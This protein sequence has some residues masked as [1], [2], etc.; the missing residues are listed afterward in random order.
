MLSQPNVSGEWPTELQ[1]SVLEHTRQ[2][3]SAAFAACGISISVRSR[4]VLRRP[5]PART[6]H[7]D[8]DVNEEEQR[9]VESLALDTLATLSAT[10]IYDERALGGRLGCTGGYEE[11][12]SSASGSE[13]EQSPAELLDLDHGVQKWHAAG[14]SIHARNNEGFFNN[15]SKHSRSLQNTYEAYYGCERDMRIWRDERRTALTAEA[16]I[17][18]DRGLPLDIY[19]ARSL[20]AP[21]GGLGGLWDE[22]LE[23]QTLGIG[24]CLRLHGMLVPHRLKKHEETAVEMISATAAAIFCDGF[25]QSMGGVSK[26]RV[27]SND[28]AEGEKAG[29]E[30]RA[31]GIAI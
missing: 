26:V 12:A 13:S 4:L 14:I 5:E 16:A 20:A 23:W 8:L 29:K 10:L 9:K 22:R 3:R 2:Y 28:L 1:R 30:W 24:I 25:P 27:L 11:H 21:C 31:P 18:I 6:V 17:V 19:E 15:R 7:V